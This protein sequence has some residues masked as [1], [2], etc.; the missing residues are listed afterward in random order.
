MSNWPETGRLF[1]EGEYGE[2]SIKKLEQLWNNEPSSFAINFCYYY[3][4]KDLNNKEKRC[5]KIQL[6]Q[7]KTA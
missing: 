6:L 7:I 1:P 4:W 3:E 5:L 2:L